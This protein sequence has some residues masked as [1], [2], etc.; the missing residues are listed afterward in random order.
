MKKS[1]SAISTDQGPQLT[2][3]IAKEFPATNHRCI[4]HI[5]AKFG[6][7]FTVVLRNQYMVWRFYNLY[8]LDTLEEFEYELKQVLEKYGFISN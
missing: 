6:G 7:W 2:E 1:P 8:K 4:W 5:T 3:A